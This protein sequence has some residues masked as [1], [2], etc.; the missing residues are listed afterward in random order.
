MGWIPY[1]SN[2]EGFDSHIVLFDLFERGER[3]KL[4]NFTDIRVVNPIPLDGTNPVADECQ[5]DDQIGDIICRY[6]ENLLSPKPSPEDNLHWYELI[7]DRKLFYVT[8]DPIPID[9]FYEWSE[10]A[11]NN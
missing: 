7:T 8:R 4:V 1:F 11:T 2:C 10:I 3:C 6:D 9:K 5:T